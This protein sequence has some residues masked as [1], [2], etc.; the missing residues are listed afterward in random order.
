METYLFMQKCWAFKRED[1]R[2][3]THFWSQP[4]AQ[5]TAG[6][7]IKDLRLQRSHLAL[8]VSFPTEDRDQQL[9]DFFTF[10]KW[11]L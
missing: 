9:E 11:F 10:A 5:E 8:I 6:F 4:Q 3:F 7:G 2:G 1:R